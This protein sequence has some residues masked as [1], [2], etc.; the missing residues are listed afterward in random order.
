[1][2]VKKVLFVIFSALFLILMFAVLELN[3]NTVIGFILT[4]VLGAG[5]YCLHRLIV[6]KKNTWYLKGAALLGWLL[7]F[8]GVVFLTW[9]PVQRVPAV[10]VKDP[11]MTDIVTVR[12][13]DLQGVYSEDK[14]FEVYAGVPFTE[15]PVGE[16]RWKEPQDAKPW[17]GVLKADHYAPMSMQPQ[18]LPIYDSLTQIIGYHD[19]EISLD[20]NYTVPVSEDSL[21]LNVWKPAGED[22]NLPVV[23]FIHGG[24]LKTGHSW[25]KDHCGEGLAK[26]GVIVVEP[27]YRLGVFGYYADEELAAES[28]NGTTGNYGM[29]D[30]I[31]ALEWVRDNI[32][33]FGG[34]PDNITLAGESAGSASV[35]ALCT[36]PL[37]KGLF[38]RV[39]MES[40]T[41]ASVNPPHSFRTMKEALEAGDKTKEEYGCTSVDELRK[42]SAEK[43]VAQAE[44]HHHMTVDGY[45]LTETPYESYKKGVHNEEAILHGYNDEE[46][47]AFII[48]DHANMKNY[49]SKLRDYFGDLTDDILAIYPAETDEQADEYW[50]E[51]YGAVFFD[52]PHY[53]LNRLAVENDIPVY[54]YLFAKQNGRLGDWHSGEEV[55]CYGNIPDGSKLYDDRDRELSAEMV[56]CWKNFAAAGDPN[57][58][59]LPKWEQNKGSDTVM[60][61]GDTTEMISEKEHALF[62][63]LDQKD[64]WN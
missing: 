63:V 10:D 24:S 43:L 32:A 57:G 41:V 51:I 19:Y 52:Y 23:V 56:G 61:F 27:A 58:G 29:L 49:E 38:K 18:N 47:A 20:D 34:D 25:Y 54:E 50:A 6:R 26:E 15:P 2:R 55:Y 7:L 13:G 39:I 35:S 1:M 60:L 62:A 37:S 48:F 22:K 30:Q 53:C 14:S 12:Q 31:K 28:T 44:H 40:S 4:A 36:S 17:D 21:Y 59:S 45:A 64:G 8:V 3:K 5:Y 33:A 9:P 16:L 11:E 46:S 42:L